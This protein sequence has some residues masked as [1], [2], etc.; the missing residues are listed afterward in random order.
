MAC[1][2]LLSFKQNMENRVTGILI[3]SSLSISAWSEAIFPHRWQPVLFSARVSGNDTSALDNLGD[4]SPSG[5]V[6]DHNV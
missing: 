5:T 3:S 6:W 4:S 2:Y 1:F